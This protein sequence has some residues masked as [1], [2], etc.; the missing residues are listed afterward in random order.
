MYVWLVALQP[1]QASPFRDALPSPLLLNEQRRWGREWICRYDGVLDSQSACPSHRLFLKCE[2]I[3]HSIQQARWPTSKGPVPARHCQSVTYVVWRRPWNVLMV[4]LMA[5]RA[6][7]MEPLPCHRTD[8]LTGITCL[9]NGQCS[10]ETLT[11]LWRGE[12]RGKFA[13]KWARWETSGRLSTVMWLNL[14]PA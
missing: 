10:G 11:V 13:V 1:G 7:V 5:S 4:P 14:C 9:R 3:L 2:G 8:V 12:M 6:R